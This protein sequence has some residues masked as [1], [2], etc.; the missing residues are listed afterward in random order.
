MT[1]RQ[2]KN[3]HDLPFE[4]AQVVA[5]HIGYWWAEVEI[6]P[7]EVIVGLFD[8]PGEPL[9]T[10][11]LAVPRCDGTAWGTDDDPRIRYGIA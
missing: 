1:T 11:R 8:G 10:R 6:T 4:V 3:L 7:D 9:L 2:L 5:H